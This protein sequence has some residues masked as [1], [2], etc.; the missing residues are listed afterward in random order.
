MF[1]YRGDIIN[2]LININIEN[3]IYK[4]R[5]KQVMLSSDVARLY[6]VETKRINEVV[7]RFSTDFCFQSTDMKY[8][9]LN[10]IY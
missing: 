9:N 2:T 3:M 7:K 6:N 8:D 1:I 10:V 4:V 5:G